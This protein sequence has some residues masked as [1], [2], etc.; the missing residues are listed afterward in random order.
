VCGDGAPRQPPERSVA[1]VSTAQ[2]PL[3]RAT[4]S[5]SVRRAT[6]RARSQPWRPSQPRRASRERPAVAQR[7]EHWK[8]RRQ[9]GWV[10]TS[11]IQVSV[12]WATA[13]SS[14]RRVACCFATTRGLPGLAWCA[15]V[16]GR[17]RPTTRV[18]ATAWALLP[19]VAAYTSA[20]IT[21]TTTGYPAAGEG[22]RPPRIDWLGHYRFSGRC[23]PAVSPPHFCLRLWGRGLGVQ[24]GSIGVIRPRRSSIACAASRQ[25]SSR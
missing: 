11:S 21:N 24:A 10:V 7:W 17:P 19:S 4:A 9:C 22:L 3:I 8:A 25:R 13:L 6:A 16:A 1:S 23:P 20:S 18:A 5:A 14:L 2:R 15:G 12:C